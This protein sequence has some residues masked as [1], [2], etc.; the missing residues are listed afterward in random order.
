MQKNSYPNT[1]IPPLVR[2]IIHRLRRLTLSYL[3]QFL[4]AVVAQGG[5]L[6]FDAAGGEALQPVFA[7]GTGER[8]AQHQTRSERQVG[9]E[10]APEFQ[11]RTEDEHQAYTAQFPRRVQQP[12]GRRLRVRVGELGAKLV[13]H[14]DVA[15]HEEPAG[16]SF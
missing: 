7:D 16:H 9:A 5:L 8:Q 11:H 10:A 1:F 13:T 3:P 6:R 15:V 2:K 4:S 12:R 14:C